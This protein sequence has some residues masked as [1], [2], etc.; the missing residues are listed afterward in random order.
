MKAA[1]AYLIILVV[2]GLTS[3]V[4][5][6]LWKGFATRR[7]IIKYPGRDRDIHKVPTPNASGVAMFGAFLVVMLVAWIMPFFRGVFRDSS[8]PLGVVL[9]AT[10]IVGIQFIDDLRDLSPPA[11]LAGVVLGASVM[12]MFGLSMFYFRIP[13]AGFVVLAPDVAPL[14]TVLWVA[15]MTQAINL[16]DGLDGLAAGI[17]AIAAAAFTIYSQRLSDGGLLAPENMGPLL[18]VIA[19]GLCLGY[20]PHNVH[21]A[22]VFMADSGAYL[23]GVL[24][25]AST[26]VVGGRIADQFSGQTYF[27]YAPIFIPLFILGVPILDVAWSIV[28]RS[29]KGTGRTEGDSEH[30]H[31]RLERMGHGQRRAVFILWSWTALLS[32]FALAPTFGAGDRTFLNKAVPFA[33]G[34]LGLGLYTFFHPGIRD[35]SKAGHPASQPPQ[36]Q[37]N[38][39]AK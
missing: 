27:F 32:A 17:V 20:L 1:T 11:K 35:K 13:F 30:I 18:A 29:A 14:M 22:K 2:S 34:A 36:W 26:L 4:L 10:I 6:W 24:M 7:G 23:L 12:Y 16:I 15:G 33:V 5:N 3:Y 38:T 39:P 19:C 21:P 37:E 28:R 25:A 31:H 8:E 9:G